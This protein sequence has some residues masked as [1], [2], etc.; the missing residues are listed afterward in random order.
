MVTATKRP[1]NAPVAVR[2][3]PRTRTTRTGEGYRQIKQR[4]L[5]CEM[6]PGARFSEGRLAADLGFAKAPIREALSRLVQEG[7]VRSIPRHGYEVIPVTV[8]DAHDLYELRLTVEP[9]AIELAAGRIDKRTLA[10]LEQLCEVAYE[11]DDRE[12]L[13][14]YADRHRE[15]HLLVVRACGNQKLSA[16]VEQ[17]F[18]ESE[19]LI[20]MGLLARDHH[21][22]MAARHKPL[23][24]ALARADGSAARQ[25]A[26]EVVLKSQQELLSATLRSPSVQS[27]QLGPGGVAARPTRVTLKRRA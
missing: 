5:R 18:E 12:A 22:D 21:H 1:R 19:R 4:I 16:V 7:L 3:E 6:A 27:A 17:V 9:R 13:A 23:L 11:P 25:I 8:R 24:E 14:N 26:T 10:R 15:F 2:E 20:Y